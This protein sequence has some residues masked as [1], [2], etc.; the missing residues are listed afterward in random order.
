M[1]QTGPPVGSAVIVRPPVVRA[2]WA[3]V[4]VLAFAFV[5]LIYIPTHGSLLDLSGLGAAV[6]IMLILAASIAVPRVIRGSILGKE[7][8]RQPIAALARGSAAPTDRLV[9]PRRRAAAIVAGA[10][11][12]AAIAALALNISRTQPVTGY[13]HAVA[14]FTFVANAA[15][16]VRALVPAPGLSGW[17]LLLALVDLRSPDDPRR[18]VH[19]THAA[20][21][22]SI[23]ATI[24]AT[25][26]GVATGAPI[27]GLLALILGLFVWTRADVAENLDIIDRFLAGRTA[28]DV[29]RPLT[30]FLWADESVRAPLPAQLVVSMVLGRDGELLGFIGPRQLVKALARDAQPVACGDAMAPIEMTELV[31]R[32]MP[33]LE[34]KPRMDRHGFAVIRMAR[35]LG[36]VEVGEL[37]RRAHRWATA[38]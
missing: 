14:T 19:A 9:S 15:L 25:A 13:P 12:S 26:Y 27:L 20:K 34:L 5:T 6:A 11:S 24:L 32:D 16:A 36:V 7:G 38:E 1:I 21:R 29:A 3:A 31:S 18:V 22:L 10:A 23:A 4:G 17:A 28:G 35:G 8:L 37:A 30:A 33:A 2:A